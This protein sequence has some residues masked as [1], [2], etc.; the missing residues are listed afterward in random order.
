MEFGIFLN[1][2]TP[3]PAAHD[4]ASEHLVLMREMELAI[5]ADKHNWKYAWFGEHHGLVEYSHMSAPEVVIGY[6]AAKTERIHLATGINSLSPR[7]EHPVRYAERAAM[8]DH[9]TEGRFEWGTGR[10]AGSHEM[11]SFN[12]MDKNST[13]TEWDEVVREIP[14]MWAQTD[15]TFEGDH[16][17]V[18]TPHDIHPKPYGESH[19]PIWVAC[20]NPA[21]FGKAGSMG[22]GAIAFNFEPVYNLKGRIEAYKEAAENPV[23]IVGDYQNNNVMM[24]NAVICLS[25][26]KRAREIALSKGRGYLVTLVNLYHDTMPKS[27]DAITWPS[28]TF[29]LSMG[30]D[31]LLDQLIEGGYMLVGTPDEVCE[32]VKAY[33]EVGCDQLV[34]GINDGMTHEENLEMIELF[35]NQVI[36]EFDKDPE[37]STTKYRR[38]AVPKFG[39][40][41]GAGPD[42]DLKVEVLPTSAVLPLPYPT[43]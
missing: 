19:P 32:Q 40:F 31:E 41:Q 5:K 1:G 16:F 11:A 35:G 21:T 26:R 33:Q 9:I 24:T 10:G 28:P 36:P 20:G 34:F 6:V 43:A 42:P 8:M 18:P 14:R 37:H 15:Y 38:N 25:D 23:E 39:R 4:R 27:A 17:T 29:D 13:K 7:K 2:Y 22:I 3:G 30:G 12:I